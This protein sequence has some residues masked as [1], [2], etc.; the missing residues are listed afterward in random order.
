MSGGTYLIV[1]CIQDQRINKWRLVL[2]MMA[3]LRNNN[4][5]VPPIFAENIPLKPT[6][7]HVLP[8]S[9]YNP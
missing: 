5:S 7:V 4:P 2:P 6:R 8:V 3:T 9:E 1:C